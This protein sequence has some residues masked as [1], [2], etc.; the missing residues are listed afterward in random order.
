MALIG[1]RPKPGRYGQTGFRHGANDPAPNNAG[2]EPSNITHSDP[3][4]RPAS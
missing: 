1:G 2:Q 4:H 3:S